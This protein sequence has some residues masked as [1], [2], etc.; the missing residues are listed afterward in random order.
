MA[1]WWRRGP[2]PSCSPVP[3][4][5]IRAR[6]WPPPSIWRRWA[7]AWSRSRDAAMGR[8]ANAVH[9]PIADAPAE[10]VIS[11]RE[12]L[13]EGFRRY[14]RIY[15]APAHAPRAG[16]PH[17]LLRA[18]PAAAVLPV[19]PTRD[20]VVLIRQFRPAAQLANGKG[21]LVEIVAGHVEAD[22]APAQAARRECVEE[23]GVAPKPLIELFTYLT[24]PGL[25]DEEMTL[26]LGVV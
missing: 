9:G 16:R 11:H 23:I 1:R 12:V 21:E 15:V 2:R 7:K 13:G 22:E 20:E 25:C 19:D 6:S 17:D 18:G 4:A 8:S 24:S 14:E 3:G 26:F 5:T 10:S